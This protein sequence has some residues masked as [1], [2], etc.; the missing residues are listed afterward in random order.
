M[1]YGIGRSGF[2]V[3]AVMRR[4]RNQI[5]AELY[6]SGDRAKAY[7]GL[8]EMQKEA[9]EQELG[10]GLEWEEGHD[11]PRYSRSDR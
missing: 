7:F 5:H 9:I 10:Y 11:G 1:A 8:L 4:P 3:A 2:H 6:V